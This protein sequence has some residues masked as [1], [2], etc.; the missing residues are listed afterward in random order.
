MYFCAI[1]LRRKGK[2]TFDLVL[3]KGLEGVVAKKKDSSMRKVC[4]LGVG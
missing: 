4:G 1:L 2:L 3:E